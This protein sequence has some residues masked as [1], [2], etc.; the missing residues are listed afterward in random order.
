MF[1]V[2]KSPVESFWILPRELSHILCIFVLF[3]YVKKSVTHISG[4]V[5]DRRLQNP[6]FYRESQHFYCKFSFWASLGYPLCPKQPIFLSFYGVFSP[7]CWTFD[8]IYTKLVSRGHSK[9]KF[10][11]EMFGFPL[12]WGVLQLSITYQ[13][14][15]MSNGLFYIG[16]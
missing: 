10:A 14:R 4:L 2:K 7:F 9:W 3:P 1:E 8:Q 13:F 6:S 12:K 16:K 11:I 5:G 15:D